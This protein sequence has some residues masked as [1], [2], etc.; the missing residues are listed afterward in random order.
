MSPNRVV[1]AVALALAAVHLEILD[2]HLPGW[3]DQ[4]LSAEDQRTLRLLQAYEA[5]MT[6]RVEAAIRSVFGKPGGTGVRDGRAH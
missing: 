1:E 2:A 4:D 5:S 3:I 6:S